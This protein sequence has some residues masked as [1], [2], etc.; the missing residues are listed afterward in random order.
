MLFGVLSGN[1]PLTLLTRTLSGR[2]TCK[3]E[4]TPAC[5]AHFHHK[6]FV[7]PVDLAKH[8]L[9][10][11]C[12]SVADAESR[13]AGLDQLLREGARGLQLVSTLDHSYLHGRHIARL[14]RACRNGIAC[15]TL[16][17]IITSLTRQSAL[18]AP[19]CIDSINDA[20]AAAEVRAYRRWLTTGAGKRHHEWSE[21]VVAE[22]G[23][24]CSLLPRETIRH[25]LTYVFE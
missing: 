3:D 19:M 7:V 12:K 25:I 23:E 5:V 14:A 18:S 16:V 11:W 21:Q 4:H 20:H 24:A 2:C 8:A 10:R 1:K 17:K 15:S 6:C 13:H 9:N 22:I